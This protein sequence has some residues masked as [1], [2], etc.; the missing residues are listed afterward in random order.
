LFTDDAWRKIVMAK[1]PDFP[2]NKT[3]IVSGIIGFSYIKEH[4]IFAR[5][6]MPN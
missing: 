6:V 4:R 5:G 2:Q 3:N 1:A